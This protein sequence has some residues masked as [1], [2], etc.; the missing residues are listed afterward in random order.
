MVNGSENGLTDMKAM[1]EWSSTGQVHAGS[2][3]VRGSVYMHKLT[4]PDQHHGST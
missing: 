4:I 1:V 3:V 2:R